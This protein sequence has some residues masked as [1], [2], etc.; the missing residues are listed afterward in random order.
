MADLV[1]PP[2][3]LR[4]ATAAPSVGRWLLPVALYAAARGIAWALG[5]RMEIHWA[6]LQL[7]DRQE[8]VERPLTA[9][10]LLHGQPP[11]LNALAAAVLAA[12]SRLGIAPETVTATLFTLLGLAGTVLLFRLALALAGS[13]AVAALVTAAAL[14]DPGFHVFSSVLFYPLP[15]WFLLLAGLA[16]AHRWIAGGGDRWLLATALALAA[17]GLTRALFHPLW[18]AGFLALTVAAR[19]RLSHRPPGATADRPQP[20]RWRPVAAAALLALGL[21]AAWPL[22]NALLFG[23]PVISSWT[24]F[25]LARGTPVPRPLVAAFIDRG[26]V[27]GELAE[28]WQRRGSAAWLRDDPLLTAVVKRP[29]GRNWNHYVFLLTGRDLTRR[30]V[31]WRL[32]HPGAWAAQAAAHYAMWARPTYVDSYWSRPRGPD[33]PLY[34]AWCAAHSA[35]LFA[36]L[37][38]LVERLTP[39]AAVHRRAVVWAGPVPYTLFALVGLPALLA[40]AAAAAWRRRGRRSAADAV[41]ALA[42]FD[43]LWTLVVPCLSDGLEGNRMRFASAPMLLLLAVY[44][45]RGLLGGRSEPC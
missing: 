5:L 7:L 10:T 21:L 42:A 8:L 20:P 23:R 31:A 25:N 35:V 37:R 22:K 15:L 18:A 6:M 16:C 40:A 12:A 29:G 13:P 11:G 2:Q 33:R 14:A 3:P 9:L 43:L 32:R 36:D 30:A 44:A 19:R 34:R 24:G 41:A 28:R 38:P 45:W 1:P 17:T 4:A 26:E 39:G 27:A